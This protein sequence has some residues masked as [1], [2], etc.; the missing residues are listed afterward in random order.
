MVVR[1]NKLLR[2]LNIGLRPLDKLLK[3]LGDDTEKLSINSK[4]PNSVA[5]IVRTIGESD[6]DFLSTIE[7]TVRKETQEKELIIN[8]TQIINNNLSEAFADTPIKYSDNTSF[9]IDELLVLSQT[10]KVSRVNLGDV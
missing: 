9:W 4:I 6:L 3:A 8:G 7:K 5:K 2:E 1:V 10:A